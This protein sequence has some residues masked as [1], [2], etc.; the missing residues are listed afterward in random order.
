M[1]LRDECADCD[2]MGRPANRAAF[3]A[4]VDMSPATC[5]SD[6]RDFPDSLNATRGAADIGEING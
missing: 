1:A 3:M 6:K 2:R 5:A 4:D